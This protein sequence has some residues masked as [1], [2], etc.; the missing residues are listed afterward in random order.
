MDKTISVNSFPD[1]GKPFLP[2][3][4]QSPITAISICQTSQPLIVTGAYDGI[5]KVWQ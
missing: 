5:I 3:G 4:H 2:H 1:L